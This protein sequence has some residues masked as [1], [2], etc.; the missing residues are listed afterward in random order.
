MKGE[1]GFSLP[2]TL[3]NECLYLVLIK[4]E[5]AE[6]QVLQSQRCLHKFLEPVTELLNYLPIQSSVLK[7]NSIVA[8]DIQRS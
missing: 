1:K 6:I 4:I 3:S 8:T 7:R 5:R 2:H